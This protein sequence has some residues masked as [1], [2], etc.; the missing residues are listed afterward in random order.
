MKFKDRVIVITGGGNGIGRELVLNLLARGAKVA[1]VDID[2]AGLEQ[3]AELS[4]MNSSSLS[5][6]IVDITD[7][8]EVSVLPQAVMDAH[9]GVD[10][11]IN[12]AGVVQPFVTIYQIDFDTIKRVMDINFYGSVYMTKAFLPY[13]LERPEAWIVNISSMGGFLPVPGQGIYGASKSAI[14]LY[15]EAMSAELAETNIQVSVVFPGGVETEIVA[16][17][18]EDIQTFKKNAGGGA[19][20]KPMKPDR[21]ARKIIKGVEKERFQIFVGMDSKFMNFL[22]RLSP[23]L[24]TNF[25]R[26]Q[27]GSLLGGH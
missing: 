18:G 17:A 9:G 16:R 25:I 19:F 10:G 23:K 12:N 11:L 20:Y 3:T 6:H 26:K 14:K 22:Y 21:A 4:D 2:Q 1:A 24:A 5:K 8:D 27:M 15:S 7:P 13:L